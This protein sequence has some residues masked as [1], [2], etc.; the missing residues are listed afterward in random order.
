MVHNKAVIGNFTYIIENKIFDLDSFINDPK[1][2]LGNIE[3]VDFISNTIFRIKEAINYQH[4]SLVVNENTFSK[5]ENIH[6]LEDSQYQLELIHLA[7]SLYLNKEFSF[8]E[9]L[10]KILEKQDNDWSD[11][12]L[13]T[14]IQYLNHP[15]SSLD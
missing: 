9:Y 12:I 7:L 13:D 15:D 4:V 8:N 11:V 5:K 14:F 3:L 6:T 10:H 2:W 1:L